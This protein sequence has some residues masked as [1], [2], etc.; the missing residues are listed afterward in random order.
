MGV[1]S[2]TRMQQTLR[3]R[4]AIMY[5]GNS[6][7]IWRRAPQQAALVGSTVVNAAKVD[8]ALV[9]WLSL[10]RGLRG[11]QPVTPQ[12]VDATRRSRV[13]VLPARIDGPDSLAAR[14]AEMVRDNVPFDFYDRYANGMASVTPRDVAA[15][16][17]KYVDLDHLIIV[18]SGERSSIEPALR[19]A[20]IA[21][22]VIVDA[23][24]K[25]IDK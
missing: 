2:G 22:V 4:R 24:G 25:P 5:S 9:E 14:I 18:V 11:E 12:E 13:G 17:S 7:V 15:A 1:I 6:G 8:S 19:A 16:A 3:D 23:N 21:P 10:L 20:N